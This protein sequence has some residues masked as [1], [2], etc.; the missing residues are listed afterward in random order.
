MIDRS[1][2]GDLGGGFMKNTTTMVMGVALAGLLVPATLRGD[3]PPPEK[4]SKVITEDDLRRARSGGTV[5]VGTP[6]APPSP[7]AT[8]EKKDDKAAKEPT[9]DERREG[10]RTSLQREIDHHAQNIQSLQKQIDD[11]QREL[12][13]STDQTLSLPGTTSG[14]RGALL[15]LVEDANAMIQQSK[16]AIEQAE[17]KARREG[18]RVNRP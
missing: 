8:E 9:E 6:D 5:S 4:K 11:A 1:P 10:V 12:N 17:E 16:D 2:S 13:D 3:G 15:K 18:I 7:E 14:R